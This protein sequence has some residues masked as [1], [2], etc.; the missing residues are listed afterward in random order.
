M[1]LGLFSL[2]KRRLREDLIILYD[3]LKRGY[4]GV[5]VFLLF[6]HV[7]S[8]RTGGNGLR[9]YQGRFSLDAKKTISKWV[10]RRWTH[11]DG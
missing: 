2:A 8:D 6:S 7:T 4:V 5:G 3:Y 9:L 10:L 11:L 1:E